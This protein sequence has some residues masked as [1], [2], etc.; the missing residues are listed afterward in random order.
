[1]PSPALSACC[2][3]FFTSSACC[4]RALVLATYT[5][6]GHTLILEPWATAWLW[7]GGASLLRTLAVSEDCH[8]VCIRCNNAVTVAWSSVLRRSEAD[9]AR[10]TEK[11]A[12]L[13][14]IAVVAIRNHSR[15]HAVWFTSASHKL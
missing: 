7:A 3:R 10:R 13:E 6:A 14:S 5:A 8:A 12:L 11:V 2:S 15:Q 4:S 9:A 1:M